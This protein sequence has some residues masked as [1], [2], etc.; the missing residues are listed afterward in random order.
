MLPTLSQLPIG[1]PK[2]PRWPLPPCPDEL[3]YREGEIVNGNKDRR[4]QGGSSVFYRDPLSIIPLAQPF[5]R[6][7]EELIPI[8]GHIHVLSAMEKVLKELYR[9]EDFDTSTPTRSDSGKAFV[10]SF[11]NTHKS[12]YYLQTVTRSTVVTHIISNGLFW[13]IMENDTQL[14]PGM[15]AYTYGLLWCNTS[16]NWTW[17]TSSEDTTAR[18]RIELPPGTQVVVDR[19]PV[20]GGKDCQF[21]DNRTSLFPDVLLPPGEFEIVSV[22]RYQDE[23]ADPDPEADGEFELLKSD[24]THSG[25]AVMSDKEYAARMLTNVSYF[26][27]VNLRLVSREG[28]PR[29]MRLPEVP[30]SADV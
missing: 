16:P 24:K 2:Q 20:Y 21:D 30:S 5:P 18:C 1:A 25:D 26:I 11:D 3:Q 22:R 12:Q 7:W 14:K 19:S 23:E 4:V 29:M 10:R 8:M 15:L 27:D 9:T 28:V 17:K 13:N 6:S